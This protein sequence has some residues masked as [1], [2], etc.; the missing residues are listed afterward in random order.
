MK[1]SIYFFVVGLVLICS[2]SCNDDAVTM[3]ESKH[4]F[5]IGWYNDIDSADPDW[6]KVIDI[7]TQRFQTVPAVM[8]LEGRYYLPIMSRMPS[9]HNK[10]VEGTFYLDQ[11]VGSP[12]PDTVFRVT[13]HLRDTLITN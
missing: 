1:K 7:S 8:E 13:K 6:F 9:F 10:V 12:M 3:G 2:F 5:V 11:P 4:Q